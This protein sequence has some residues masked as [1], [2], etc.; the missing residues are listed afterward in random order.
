MANSNLNIDESYID[1]YTFSDVENGT[2]I[3]NSDYETTKYNTLGEGCWN[4]VFIGDTYNNLFGEGCWN[5]TFLR[6]CHDNTIKWNSVG[7]LLMKMYVIQQDL[8]ITKVGIGNTSLSM[9]ITKTIQKVN[10]VTLIS[11]LDPITYAYQ[12]IFL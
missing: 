6:G 9:T 3:E 5:N 2:V 8:F 11:F 4:N 7:N 10:D 1:L 12:I